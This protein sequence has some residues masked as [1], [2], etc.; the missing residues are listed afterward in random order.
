MTEHCR[1][2]EHCVKAY[3]VTHMLSVHCDANELEVLITEM[4]G[5]DVR[6]KSVDWCLNETESYLSI[7]FPKWRTL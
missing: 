3:I 7:L 1:Q 5:W 4:R 2:T 6:D